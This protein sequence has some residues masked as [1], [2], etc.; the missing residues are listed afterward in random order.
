MKLQKALENR[1]KVGRK[2]EVWAKNKK[3]SWLEDGSK[4]T[5]Y[6]HMNF[7]NLSK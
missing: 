3:P 5:N 2:T 6:N 1:T 4:T 7:Q